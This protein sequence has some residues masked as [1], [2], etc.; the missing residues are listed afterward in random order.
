MRRDGVGKVDLTF[1]E[2]APGRRVR[3]LE[4]G[5]EHAGARVQR[6]DNH[7][8]VSGSGDLNAAILEIGRNGSNGPFGFANVLRIRQKIGLFA[9][10]EALLALFA[11][12]KQFQTAS[13]KPALKFSKK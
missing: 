3:V 7:L 1:N 9:C 2:I 11:G 8:A 13:I 4:V 6:I 5:H 12:G 10:I